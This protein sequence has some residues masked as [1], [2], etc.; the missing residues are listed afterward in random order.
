MPCL[1]VLSG[2]ARHGRLLY[3]PAVRDPTLA[4]RCAAVRL[5]R[6]RPRPAP[7]SPSSI[8]LLTQWLPALPSAAAVW[9]DSSLAAAKP[10]PTWSPQ[11]HADRDGSGL[12]RDR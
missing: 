6:D 4:A 7:E 10:T 5:I 12:I 3:L 9:T 2:P 11:T 1:D 8:R